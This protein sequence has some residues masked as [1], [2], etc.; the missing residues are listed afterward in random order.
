MRKPRRLC[1]P[2][3]RSEMS[4]PICGSTL[5]ELEYK[6]NKPHLLAAMRRADFRC[7]VGCPHIDLHDKVVDGVNYSGKTFI[8]PIFR[9]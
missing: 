9:T 7:F 4:C 2:A 3:C 6:G 5:V 1:C 8:R